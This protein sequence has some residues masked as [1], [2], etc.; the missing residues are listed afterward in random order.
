MVHPATAAGRCRG[1]AQ[2]C[3]DDTRRNRP[4]LWSQEYPRRCSPGRL[5][6]QTV[7]VRRR[8]RKAACGRHEVRCGPLG[9]HSSQH[10]LRPRLD[11]RQPQGSLAHYWSSREE[12][13]RLRRRA[14]AAGAGALERCHRR[15]SAC[16]GRAAD[17]GRAPDS[18]R[19]APRVPPTRISS[20]PNRQRAYKGGESLHRLG[21]RHSPVVGMRPLQAPRYCSLRAALT[22]SQRSLPNVPRVRLAAE[23]EAV[24]LEEAAAH[25]DPDAAPAA[26]G[27]LA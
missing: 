24:G 2:R 10:G 8:Y 5:A 17:S 16:V 1:R 3:R 6:T 27:R 26:G 11:E 19:A 20:V 18:G 25:A 9:D 22:A 23:E 7:L 13:Q 15:R 21:E 4:A 14:T 12:Q